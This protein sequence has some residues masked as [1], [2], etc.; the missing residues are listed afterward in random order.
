[1]DLQASIACLEVIN[2]M[3]D[4]IKNYDLSSLK[5]DFINSKLKTP[6][7]LLIPR[8]LTHNREEI[9]QL[10]K[11]IDR[12]IDNFQVIQ[13]ISRKFDLYFFIKTFGVFHGL[14]LYKIWLKEKT[15]SL[16]NKQKLIYV[17][18]KNIFGEGLAYLLQK[19]N[20]H[21]LGFLD[22]NKELQGKK[23]LGLEV[24]SPNILDSKTKD[25]LSNILVLICSHQKK[26]FR[27][28]SKQLEQKGLSIKQLVSL[29]DVTNF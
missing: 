11:I 18:C 9:L 19:E 23:Y 13:K 20:Y 16:I 27:N 8:L 15:I 28:I 10:S 2:D 24:S 29:H 26:V 6:L 4:L 22:N 3:C 5:V 1:M 12:Y 14:I 21:V 25:E 17:F 7:E